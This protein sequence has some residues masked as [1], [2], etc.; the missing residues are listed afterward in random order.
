MDNPQKSPDEFADLHPYAGLLKELEDLRNELKSLEQLFAPALQQVHPRHL[1]SAINLV[2]YL[3]IR[4]RDMRPLQERLAAAGLSSL[5][6]MESHVLANLNAI[7]ELLRCALGSN[8]ADEISPH[9]RRTAGNQY[10]QPVRQ[11]SLASPRPHHGHA[12]R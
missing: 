10:K 12:S 6:R 5:G 4:R 9:G 2:H 8:P 7:I 1:D 11:A 3:G